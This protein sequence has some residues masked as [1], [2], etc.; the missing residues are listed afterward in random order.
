MIEI[1]QHNGSDVYDM[2]QYI[3]QQQQHEDEDEEGGYHVKVK[4]MNDIS[5]DIDNESNTTLFSQYSL[6]KYII[7]CCQNND[8]GGLRDKPGKSRDYYHSC[9]ALSG[10]SCSQYSYLVKKESKRC[11][12]LYSNEL[13]HKLDKLANLVQ[14]TSVVY[15]IGLNKLK[16]ALDYFNNNN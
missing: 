2:E 9:Y 7:H 11:L 10:L 13:H 16:N 5:D 14:P 12:Y 3:Q 6:Q 4:Y 8:Y 1:I 15:N